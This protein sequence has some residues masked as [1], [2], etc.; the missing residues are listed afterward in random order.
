MAM[1]P[2]LEWGERWRQL[3]LCRLVT[4]RIERIEE[5]KGNFR[6]KPGDQSVYGVK[7][8]KNQS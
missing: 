4:K 3:Q 7:E 2:V 8:K 6:G 5:I 1:N